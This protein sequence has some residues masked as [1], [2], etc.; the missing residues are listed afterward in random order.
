MKGLTVPQQEAAEALGTGKSN[1]AT[2]VLVNVVEGTIR[3]WLKLPDFQAAVLEAS[4]EY[5]SKVQRRL[6][7]YALRAADTV[8]KAGAMLVEPSAPQLA[9]AKL[10]LQA[11]GVACDKVAVDHGGK[12]RVE[13]EVATMTL[14][15]LTA[16]REALRVER[17]DLLAQLA[18]LDDGA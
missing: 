3:N 8:G 12:V 6:S 9:A 1:R 16:E 5:K 18:G 11:I 7:G 14:E 15:Q 10:T 2:A 17:E 4:A 13:V